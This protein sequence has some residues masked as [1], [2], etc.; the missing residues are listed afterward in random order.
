LRRRVRR[1]GAGRAAPR[2]VVPRAGALRWGSFAR[3]RPA[4]ARASLRR[5]GAR[6][7]RGG[8]HSRRRTRSGPA[9]DGSGHHRFVPRG[10]AAGRKVS[11]KEESLVSLEAAEASRLTLTFAEVT[12]DDLP[13]VGG[14]GTNLGALTRAGVS[15]PPGFCVTTRA[16]DRFIAALP[17]RVVH[18]A[19][20]DALAAS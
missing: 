11:P 15:V 1:Q 16:F 2:L 12:A 5:N 4:P 8:A 9:A 6:V 3:R 7:R 17:D 20:L 19:R 14:K 10:R 13:R 18:F